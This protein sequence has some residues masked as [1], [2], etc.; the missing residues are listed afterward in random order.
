MSF[1]AS[2]RGGPEVS[3]TFEA[4]GR[5]VQVNG[6]GEVKV[7][8]DTAIVRLGVDVRD[9]DL[10]AAQTEAARRMTA[11]IDAVKDAGVE[12]GNVSTSRYNIQV[13]YD[14][15]SARR[16]IVGYSVS[17]LIIAKLRVTDGV[18]KVIKAGLEAGAN[19]VNG[20][21]FVVE[22][23]GDAHSRAREAAIAN[24]R[25]KAED[26]ARI[27]GASLG[28]VMRIAESSYAPRAMSADT[29]MFSRGVMASAPMMA[30]APIEPG[31]STIPVHVEVSWELV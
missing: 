31:E 28:K 18:A 30:E 10:S 3:V 15:Q 8:P 19:E 5:H 7:M 20:I 4:I 29:A 26:L 1:A 16:P 17:H 13:H 6:N 2:S 21:H 23:P 11:T 9:R 14:H 12:E 24:A 27:A 22:D 25:E